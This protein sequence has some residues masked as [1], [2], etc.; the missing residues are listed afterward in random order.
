MNKEEAFDKIRDIIG[1]NFSGVDEILDRYLEIQNVI[2]SHLN[3]RLCNGKPIYQ[4]E[5]ENDFIDSE[6][7]H[8]TKRGEE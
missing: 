1:Q 3:S 6:T 4:C 7:V 5:E 2:I 8:N